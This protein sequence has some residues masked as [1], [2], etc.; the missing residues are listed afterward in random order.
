ML[1]SQV[2]FTRSPA[3]DFNWH[4]TCCL[5]FQSY[6]FNRRPLPDKGKPVARRGRKATGQASGLIAELPKEGR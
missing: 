1:I 6:I 3:S 4:V 5:N 2:F